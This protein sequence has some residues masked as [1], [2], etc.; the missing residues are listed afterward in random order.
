MENTK[1]MRIKDWRVAEQK[2]RDFLNKDFG[3]G[4]AA[5]AAFDTNMDGILSLDE[6][7]KGLAGLHL[8]LTQSQLREV[9]P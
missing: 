3:G 9:P 7:E 8:G 5:F 1:E 2:I 4:R 6:F